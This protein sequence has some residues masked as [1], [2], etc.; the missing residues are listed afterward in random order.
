VFLHSPLKGAANLL[1]M[2]NADAAN[3]SHNL[4]KEITNSVSVGP[5]T[6]WFGQTGAYS[7]PLSECAADHQYDC[8]CGGRCAGIFAEP[9]TCLIGK[10]GVDFSSWWESARGRI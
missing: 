6:A 10:R 7:D 4:L 2:P 5:I 3:I 1:I 8:D 9:A